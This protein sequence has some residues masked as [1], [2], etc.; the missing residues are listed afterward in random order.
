VRRF[1]IGLTLAAVVAFA[2]LA[3]LGVWQLERLAWK[4]ALLARIEAL[5][6][7]PPRPIGPVLERLSR[8]QDV[9][10]TRVSLSCAPPPTAPPLVYRYALRDGQVAWRLITACR[11]I[12]APYDGVLLDRGLV[13]RFE[14]LMAP[15]AAQFTPPAAVVGVLTAPGARPLIDTAAPERQGEVTLLRLIDRETIAQVAAQSGLSHAAPV[16]AAV[17]REAPAPDGVTPAALPR[18][19]P[20]NHLVY[21]L[22]WFTL[23]GIL[24]WF[25]VAMVWRR[26]RSR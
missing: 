3:G 9:A 17:E 14:G 6:A 26:L 1:P 10:F 15:L 19:I 2:L 21:A 20:N 22:T 11:L 13:A 24:A 16:L 5:R 8:G 23:A 12:G 25:Y 4:E 18:D 7:A